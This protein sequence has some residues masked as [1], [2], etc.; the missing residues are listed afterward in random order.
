MPG[1]TE[2]LFLLQRALK[3]KKKEELAKLLE[4]SR[5]MLFNYEND[6]PPPPPEFL[7]RLVE[8]ERRATPEQLF[9][10]SEA[11]VG[12]EAPTYRVREKSRQ[13]PVIGWAHAGE[14][15]SYEE[16]APSWVDKVPTECRD[17]KAFA[18]RLEGDSME[19]DFKDG[20]ILVVMPQAEPYS[21]C[22]VV[23]RFKDDGVVFRRLET[24]GKRI[25]LVPLNERY[26]VTSHEEDEFAWIYPVWGRWSQLWKR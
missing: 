17:D 4:V 10:G 3:L 7:S 26:E 15:A 16:I 6:D 8:L 19:R 20:D 11:R 9:A 18:V 1:L 21:G 14:A 22:F 25:L 13:I 12:E 24:A 5:T 2:R 23:A